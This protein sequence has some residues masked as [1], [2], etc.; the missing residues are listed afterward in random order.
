M[1]EFNMD[2]QSG[3]MNLDAKGKRVGEREASVQIM[4][5]GTVRCPNHGC[6]L[7][8]VPFPLPEKGVGRCPVSKCSFEFESKIDP[9]MVVTLKDGTVTKMSRWE[10]T[11]SEEEK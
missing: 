8:G 1:A 3:G 7:E 2:D 6:E 10:V 4:P 5:S 11:G 9:D